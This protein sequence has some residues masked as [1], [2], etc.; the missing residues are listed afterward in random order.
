[1]LIV[2]AICLFVYGGR[3]REF[4]TNFK[5]N[6]TPKL[7]WSSTDLLK[8]RPMNATNTNKIQRNGGCGFVCA[9]VFARLLCCTLTKYFE[10]I[11]LVSIISLGLCNARRTTWGTSST[12]SLKKRRMSV[13]S[14]DEVQRK[15]GIHARLFSVPNWSFYSQLLCLYATKL[16]KSIFSWGMTTFFGLWNSAHACSNLLV[17]VH[18]EI[19]I[20]IQGWGEY[21]E[22]QPR[23][24]FIR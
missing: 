10:D 7:K 6:A 4:A 8:R 17:L 5:K 24:T 13:M 2:F 11:I 15:G 21:V 18:T 14:K 9:V 22:V 23:D 20:L 16:F 19:F 12:D 1:M 3:N